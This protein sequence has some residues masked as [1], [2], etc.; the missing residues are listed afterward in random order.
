[1]KKARECDGPKKEKN[2][3]NNYL[4]RQKDGERENKFVFLEVPAEYTLKV[5]RDGIFF[6]SERWAEY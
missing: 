3:Q 6:P 5:E 1:M 2:P 4:G